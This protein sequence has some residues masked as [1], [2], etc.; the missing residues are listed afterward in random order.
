MSSAEPVELHLPYE[1]LLGDG[2][3][4]TLAMLCPAAWYFGPRIGAI[5]ELKRI[6]VSI[7]D[8]NQFTI[9]YLIEDDAESDS[10]K[11]FV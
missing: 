8:N 2:M 10:E 5:S 7:D 6:E 11:A 3:S 1:V 4:L 9:E